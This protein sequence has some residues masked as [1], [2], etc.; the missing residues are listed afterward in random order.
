MIDTT[1]EIEANVCYVQDVKAA[2]EK[3][4]LVQNFMGS[5]AGTIP[6]E[7]SIRESVEEVAKQ[8]PIQIKKEAD[9]V[10]LFFDASFYGKIA[11]IYSLDGSLVKNFVVSS[12]QYVQ[13]SEGFYVLSFE[14]ESI[15]FLCQ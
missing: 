11:S 4:W 13:L 2:K 5:V 10:L 1:K 9:G 6:Y 12:E 7:G 14:N 8:I 3:N 15:K